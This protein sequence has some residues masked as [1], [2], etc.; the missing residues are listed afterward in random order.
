MLRIRSMSGEVLVTIELESF[1]DTLAA[2]SQPVRALKQHLH[3][4]CRQPRFR[5]RL[6]FLED[7]IELNDNDEAHVLKPGDMQLVLV[8]F[9]S[10]PAVQ[11]ELQHAAENRLASVV[12]GILQRP[13]FP[14]IGDPTP[15]LIASERSHFQVACLLL[16]AKADK[17]KA[18]NR[19]ATSLFIAAQTGQLE[20]ARLL[21][22]AKAD[23]DKATIHGGTPV[24]VA[25]ETGHS[26][27]ASL[28][29]ESKA[30]KDKATI[31]G[32]TQLFIAAETGHLEVP[33]LLLDAKAAKDIAMNDSE[34]WRHPI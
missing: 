31:D 24:C 25:A 1:L 21:L 26:E 20:V 6:L 16:E 19:D 23:K 13:H 5:Q 4:F 33:R 15:L 28:L 11:E 17:D 18:T 27:V 22:E 9:N 14:D 30:D 32:A 8:N 2:G 3:S 29:L 12:E 10:A 7:S 34:R